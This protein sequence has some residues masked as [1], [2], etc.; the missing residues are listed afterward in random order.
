M[1]ILLTGLMLAAAEPE[2]M[3]VTLSS[4]PQSE[5]R[6]IIVC[7]DPTERSRYRID[8]AITAAEKAANP[9]NARPSVHQSIGEEPCPPHGLK[10]CP[11]L[12]TVPVLAIARVA[13]ESA[14]LASNGEDWRAPLRTQ[15]DQYAL[16]R[17]AKAKEERRKS[18]RKVRFG[19]FS[20]R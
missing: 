14:V 15:S 11:G 13:L 17:D 7:A 6:Q 2:P 8:P 9:S 19:V 1:S 16:Y 4:C 20:R 10:L 12:D 3:K 18:D 5:E